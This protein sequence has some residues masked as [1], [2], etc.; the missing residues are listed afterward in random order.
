MITEKV[1]RVLFVV[2]VLGT[3]WG[4]SKEPLPENRDLFLQA[5]RRMVPSNLK[6]DTLKAVIQDERFA[7]L[8]YGYFQEMMRDEQSEKTIIFNLFDD[9]A[10]P[11]KTLEIREISDDLILWK[12]QAVQGE[13]FDI[14]FVLK[15]RTIVGRI[16]TSHG[17]FRVVPAGEFPWHAITRLDPSEFPEEAPTKRPIQMSSDQPAKEGKETKEAVKLLC[18]TRGPTPGPGKGPRVSIM[19]L[20]TPDVTSA[21]PGINQEINLAMEG[22]RSAFNRTW[23]TAFPILVHSGEITYTETNNLST[24]VDWL[25]DDSTVQSLR[26]THSADLVVLLTESG[27]SCGA[28]WAPNP[29]TSGTAS[30]GFSAVRRSCIPNLSFPH[31]IG[32][33]LG[34]FHDR[35]VE[36]GPHPTNYNYGYVNQDGR[37]RSIMA[38]NRQ[39]DDA[40]LTCRRVLAFSDPFT[41]HKGG[42]LGTAIGQPKPAH[43]GETFCRHAGI[44]SRYR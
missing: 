17:L 24:D 43:N 42:T 38:Y 7:P 29:V 16:E 9:V 19:V 28:A 39:C 44:V 35:H 4:C 12:G 5:D 32:H 6:H 34:M 15:D 22:L 31:E 23:F 11:V 36:S 1:W 40:G 2:V 25:S 41:R 30:R 13:S 21:S 10:F 18:D 26:D 27:S 3:L 33:N 14:S 37:I 8:N 20:W